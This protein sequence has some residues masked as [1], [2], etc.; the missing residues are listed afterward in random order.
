[1]AEKRH[2]KLILLVDDNP[3]VLWAFARRLKERYEVLTASGVV[4]AREILG[5]ELC[6]VVVSDFEM[7]GGNGLQLLAW[8]M[9]Q[10]P[11][12]LRIL[13]SGGCVPD[14]QEHLS[15]GLL[16]GFLPKPVETSELVDL[17][18]HVLGR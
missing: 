1:M 16:L 17:I 13:V 5:R 15:S 2:R 8:V 11:Q 12:A 14:L 6:D 10:C 4:E 7:P 3:A 9:E 18:G